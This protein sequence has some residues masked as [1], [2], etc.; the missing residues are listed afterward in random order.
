VKGNPGVPGGPLTSNPTWSNASGYSATSAFFLHSVAR[1]DRKQLRMNPMNK[2]HSTMAQQIAEAASAFEER[3]TGHVP[4]SVT[5]VLSDNTLVITLHEAMSPAERALA[6]SPAGAARMQEFHRQLFA[7]SA[8]SLRQEITRITGVEVREAAVEVE[9]ATGTV[10][11]AFTTGT[12]VQ[13][14]LLAGSVPGETW[15]GSGRD[16]HLTPGTPHVTPR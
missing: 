4:K 2:L 15:S 16:G 9:P 13:V 8:D 10:V 3:R 7:N 6:N 5:V 12:V 11:K 1:N 14:F